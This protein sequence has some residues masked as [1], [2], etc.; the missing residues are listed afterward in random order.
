MIQCCV[1]CCAKLSKPLLSLY[2]RTPLL[3]CVPCHSSH[4]AFCLSGVVPQSCL[5]SVSLHV[6]HTFGCASPWVQWEQQGDHGCAHPTSLE[7]GGFPVHQCQ[8]GTMAV[9]CASLACQVVG[10]SCRFFLWVQ[11][12]ACHSKES[13]ALSLAESVTVSST[14]L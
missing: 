10:I 5:I 12:E 9:S 6:W 3:H 1:W 2:G 11:Y 7:P 13:L 4:S 8:T 14:L